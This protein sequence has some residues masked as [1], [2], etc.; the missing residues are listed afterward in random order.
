MAA[1]SA[2]LARTASWPTAARS[3]LLL[4]GLLLFG[5]SVRLMLDARVGVGPWDALNAGLVQHVPI[6]FGQGS[7]LI[8]AVLVA[9]AYAW[10]RV[11]PGLGTVLNMVLIGVFIDLLAPFSPHPTALPVQW[12]QFAFGVLLMGFATGTY[13]A[14]RFGAGPRDG[15][16]LGLG[17]RYAWPVAR[18]RTGVELLV[19]A[20]AVVLGG[21]VGWGTLAFAL[22]IGP[23]MALGLRLYGLERRK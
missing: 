9:L 16:V 19:V 20:V 14:S 12:A 11:R 13:I 15:L 2:P 7:I 21:P 5:A 22:S 10:L 17:E 8:G 4:V 23:S 18:V 3:A 1:P 6:T